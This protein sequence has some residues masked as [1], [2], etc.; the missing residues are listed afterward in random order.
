MS[1]STRRDTTSCS[2]WCRSA[3]TS[4]EEISSG[5]CIIKPFILSPTSVCCGAGA[6]RVRAGSAPGIERLQVTAVATQPL[7]LHLV[8]R[9]LG[10]AAQGEGRRGA[11]GVALRTGEH[12][13]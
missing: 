5:T 13:L 8:L 4:S 7:A 9:D 10:L 6:S 3:C 11:D 1:P 2:P 12:R